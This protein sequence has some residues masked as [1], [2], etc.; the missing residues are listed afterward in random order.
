MIG[1]SAGMDN[2]P[3]GCYSWATTRRWRGRRP[4]NKCAT[5]R[6]CTAGQSNSQAN[7]AK[8]CNVDAFFW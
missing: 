3:S 7:N 4:R 8:S 2:L 5:L 1:D 6:R